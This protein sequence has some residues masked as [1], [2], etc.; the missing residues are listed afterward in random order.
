MYGVINGAV[1]PAREARGFIKSVLRWPGSVVRAR[2][3]ASV[4][5]K[6]FA[7]VLRFGGTFLCRKIPAQHRVLRAGKSQ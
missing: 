4:R 6:Y 7:R 3:R 1:I 5:V 2:V